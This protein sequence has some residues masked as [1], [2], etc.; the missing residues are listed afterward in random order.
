[1]HGYSHDV[2]RVGCGGG[3]GGT[4]LEQLVGAGESAVDADRAVG[5]HGAD[6]VVRAHLDAVLDV[7]RALQADAKPARLAELRQLR[8]LAT[9]SQALIASRC[10]HA[11]TFYTVDVHVHPHVYVH[12]CRC[13]CGNYMY[14]CA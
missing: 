9:K 4:Y 5:E 2:M 7:H 10:V 11:L 14:I 6:V 3:G 13:I 8:H 12:V 1:M